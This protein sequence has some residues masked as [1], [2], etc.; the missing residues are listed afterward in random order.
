MR[1]RPASRSPRSHADGRSVI[2]KHPGTGGAVTVE[3]V[4]AQ[5]LYEIG[6]PRYLGPDVTTR[7]DTV[8]LAAG[9]PG[10]GADHR[11][12]RRAAAADA[13]GRR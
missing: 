12:A 6:G 11:R 9:R 5:L 4:T 8:E 10:P 13:E 1:P 7:F 2:T 3:T